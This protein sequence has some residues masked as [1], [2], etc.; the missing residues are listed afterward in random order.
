[1][2]REKIRNI[3]IIAHVDH[4]K[5][6]L[7]DAMLKQT[8]TFR[9]NEQV[10]ERIMD[11]ND[12]EKERGITILAKN[13][14]LYYKGI[15]I[16]IVDTPGHADFGGEV[17]RS[18]S[19]VDG[20]VLLVDAY[21]GCMPQTR[22]VLKKALALGLVPVI[23]VNKIDRPMARPQEV[24]NEMYD[25][26]ID[27]GA[28]EEQLDLPVIYASGRDGWATMDFNQKTNNL[29]CLFD[30]IIEA[31]PCPQVE[32][33]AP[34]QMMVS[35]IDFNEYTGRMAVGKILRGSLSEKSPVSIVRRNGDVEKSKVMGIY[36][37]ESLKKKPATFAEA[38]DIVCLTGLADIEIGDTVC[39]PEHPEGLPFVKIEDPVLS[40]YF[41]VSTSPFAGQDGTYVTSRH[42][43]ER[44]YR[45]LESNISLRVE[46]TDTTDTLKVSGRGELHLSV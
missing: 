1:M 30:L 35:N 13:T 21:E 32:A 2:E 4:G 11:S 39:D 7:V 5:T 41:S 29:T 34:F 22:T 3:A 19:M 43:R 17:E 23:V 44:L 42:I 46:D 38:G 6:T 9:E 26:L 25:L 27:L 18:L 33:D 45:E 28:T 36:T 8:G 14:S 12:L 31:I 15:K 16:N 40:M 10:E 20:V 37:F 24:T